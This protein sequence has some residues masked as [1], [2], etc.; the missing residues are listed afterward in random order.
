MLLLPDG[1]QRAEWLHLPLPEMVQESRTGTAK[2]AC[3]W[4][5]D[6]L[7]D[8]LSDWLRDWLSDYLSEYPV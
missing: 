2:S 1:S 6:W 5:S 3:E 7:R 8:W 4:M